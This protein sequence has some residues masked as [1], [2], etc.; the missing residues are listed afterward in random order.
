MQVEHLGRSEPVVTAS[1]EERAYRA[2]A[3][4]KGRDGNEYDLD[5]VERIEG[6]GFGKKQKTLFLVLEAWQIAVTLSLYPSIVCKY[7]IQYKYK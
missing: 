3:L 5:V 6:I 2:I 7:T 4:R 1:K